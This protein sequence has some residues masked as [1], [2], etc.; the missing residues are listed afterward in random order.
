MGAGLMSDTKKNM[1]MEKAKNIGFKVTLPSKECDDKHCPFHANFPLRGRSQT[2]KVVKMGAQ[3]SASVQ[4][5]RLFHIPKYQRYEKRLS[6]VSVHVPPCLD[7]KV[8]DMVKIVESRP[9]S[10]MKNFVIVEKIEK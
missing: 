5:L 6:K 9:I 3:K 10:K 1:K 2:G 4:W 8:G 7:I